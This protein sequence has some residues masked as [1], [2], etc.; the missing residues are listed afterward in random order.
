VNGV[1]EDNFTSLTSLDWQVHLYGDASGA[2]AREIQTVCDGRKLPLHVF[3]WRAE[4]DRAGLQR[5]AVY[6]VRPDGYVAMAV[7]DP[8]GGA[9]AIATY[10]DARRIKTR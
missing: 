6:L 4:M 10:L 9:T 1:D 5:E 3:R 2:A 8:G 7:A